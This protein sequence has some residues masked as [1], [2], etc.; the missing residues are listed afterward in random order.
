MATYIQD[1]KGK[2]AGSIGDGKNKI[3]TPGPSPRLVTSANN[4]LP[5]LSLEQFYARRKT[6]QDLAVEKANLPS[7]S[8]G[9]G[10]RKEYAVVD[11]DGNHIWGVTTMRA[12]ADSFIKNGQY[13]SDDELV[14]AAPGFGAKIVERTITASDWEPINAGNRWDTYSEYT[15]ISPDGQRVGGFYSFLG[16]AEEYVEEGEF[17]Y[18]VNEDGETDYD[19]WVQTR[20]QPPE[21]SFVV[22]RKNITSDWSSSESEE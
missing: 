1:S 6:L 2:M 15:V 11:K 13:N 12:F 5:G 19:S 10:T 22:A 4:N 18:G 16:G 8:R 7:H 17:S 14:K 3:P 20:P 21:G 9:T